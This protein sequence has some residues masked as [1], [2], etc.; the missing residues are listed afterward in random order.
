M[1]FFQLCYDMLYASIDDNVPP[2]SAMDQCHYPPS[3]PFPGLVVPPFSQVE[4]LNAW[5]YASN[6]F[7]NHVGYTL[8]SQ[9][10]G[11]ATSLSAFDAASRS[12]RFAFSVSCSTYRALRL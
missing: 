1:S 7:I 12:P 6:H 2:M 3:P 9:A 11:T 10:S 8:D 4:Y 5:L